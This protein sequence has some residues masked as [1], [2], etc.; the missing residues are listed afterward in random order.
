M[1]TLKKSGHSTS[2]RKQILDSAFNG[3]NKMLEEDRMGTKPLFRNRKWNEKE[4]L[5]IKKKKKL[6]QPKFRS[7]VYKCSI[8]SPQGEL[9][10]ELKQREGEMNKN[11]K[12]RIKFIEKSCIKME[13]ML[14]VKDPLPVKN[15]WGRILKYV[16]CASQ[17]EKKK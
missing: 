16:W 7:S 5:E 14:V 17:Q 10:K 15:V 1:L 8:C 3:F 2:Y 4:R 11:S 12:E 9:L 13:E 6:V